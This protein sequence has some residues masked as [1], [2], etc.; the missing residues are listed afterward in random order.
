METIELNTV[1]SIAIV[2]IKL[3]L[4]FI[5]LM[6][7]REL[8]LPEKTIKFIIERKKLKDSLVVFGD[9]IYGIGISILGSVF[10]LD[11][12]LVSL[13]SHKGAIGTS[14]IILGAYIRGKSRNL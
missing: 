10:F 8:G 14:L 12:N 9:A 6:L 2:L 1:V 13:Y 4:S 3:I 5:V 7:F 11:P